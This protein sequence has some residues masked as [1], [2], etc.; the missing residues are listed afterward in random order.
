MKTMSSLCGILAAVL[1]ILPATL[2]A[3][4]MSNDEVVADPG[5]DIKAVEKVVHTLFDAMRAKDADTVRTLFIEGAVLQS[6]GE[7]N[8]EPTLGKMPMENFAS[9]LENFEGPMW[10]E[11]IW[12]L[13]IQVNNRLASA[14]MDYAFFL[15]EEFSHCGVNS[16][17]LFNGKE[18]WKIIYLADSRQ[19]EG[20][21]IPESV[22]AGVN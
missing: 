13:N 14:W 20:C 2:S 4:P 6:A 3:Q 11:K 5:E 16:F 9:A 1:L 7:Q 18:G 19:Q 10:N 17:Q 8:G 22:K 15:G 21:E 12:N